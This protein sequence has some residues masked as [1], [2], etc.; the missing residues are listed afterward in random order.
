[1]ESGNGVLCRTGR[2]VEANIDLRL[3]PV[4]IGRARGRPEFTEGMEAATLDLEN[5][6]NGSSPGAYGLVHFVAKA[7][8]PVR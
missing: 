4:R 5:V 3:G 7:K 1:M 2:V 8:R 6:R